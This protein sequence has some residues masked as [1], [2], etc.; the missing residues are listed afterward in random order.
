VLLEVH[1]GIVVVQDNRG[2]EDENLTNLFG[3]CRHHIEGLTA[4]KL[5]ETLIK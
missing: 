3:R 1:D 2:I 5:P 4:M